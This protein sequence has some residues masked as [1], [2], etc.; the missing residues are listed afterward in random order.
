MGCSI[1]RSTVY[2]QLSKFRLSGLVVA[3]AAGGYVMGSGEVVEWR[4]LAALCAG[5]MAA[6]A[7]ANTCNQLIEIKLDALMSRTRCALPPCSCP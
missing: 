3:T 6:S 1:D 2:K 4:G 5:T 7:C